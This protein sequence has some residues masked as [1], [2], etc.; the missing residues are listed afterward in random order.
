MK[1]NVFLTIL[2]ILLGAL[3]FYAFYISTDSLL[4]S[5]IIS[6]TCTLSLIG[7]MGLSLKDS[8][9][10]TVMFKMTAGTF[11]F[12]FLVMN[13]C[14]VWLTVSLPVLIIANSVLFI[15]EL[16]VLYAVV[17]AGE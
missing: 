17:K 16:I 5:G 12:I 15:L 2:A 14:F 9:R 11:F 6:A 13:I 10:S 4:R 8:P 1:T 7:W 3:I